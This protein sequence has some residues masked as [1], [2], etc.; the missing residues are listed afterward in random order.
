MKA[1]SFLLIAIAV[2]VISACSNHGHEQIQKP[3]EDRFTKIVLD[4]GLDEPMELAIAKDGRIVF[5]ERKGN[6]KFYDPSTNKTKVMTKLNVHTGFEDGLLGVA[7]DPKFMENGWLYFY[8]SVA[9]EKPIQRV[10]RFKLAGDSLILST[11][12]VIL[13]IPVQRETCCH[14]AGSLAFGKDNNLYIAIGDN[15]SSKQSD[16]YTPIDERPGRS[17]YDAQKSSSNT[18]DLRGKILRIHP[19]KNG[20]YTIPKGNLFPEDGSKGRPE[21]YVMGCRNPYRISTDIKNGWLFWGDV[22]PD[23]G[24]DDPKGRGPQSFDEFN[25]AKEPGNFGWPY[26]VGNNFPY[27][28]F[29]FEDSALGKAFDPSHPENDS[30]HNT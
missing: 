29:N 8:Y 1:H 17:P 19:E 25:L 13:E 23:A 4:Y 3:D 12:K 18:Q 2:A 15:T 7:M 22:G 9:G 28:D 5:V 14:S 21:I 24:A 26:F 27:Y 11:E 30:P 10:S 6:I 16:G 20:T